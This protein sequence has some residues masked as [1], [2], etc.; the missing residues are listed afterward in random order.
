MSR[1]RR[2]RSGF[3]CSREGCGRRTRPSR[4]YCDHMCGYLDTELSR[5]EDLY[6][7]AGAEDLSPDA[8]T[9]L[10]AVSDAWSEF[11]RSRGALF[12]EIRLRDLPVPS[13]PRREQQPATLG[14]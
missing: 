10:V 9:T 13:V 14:R 12:R 11:R 5:L 3:R 4:P 8:W 7:T 1:N 2:P 6:R